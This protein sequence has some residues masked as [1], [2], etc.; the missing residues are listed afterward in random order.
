MKTFKIKKGLD[1]PLKGVPE[2]RIAGFTETSFYGL[3]G[4]DYVG[5]KPKILVNEGDFVRKGEALF[6]HKK[7]ERIKFT[8]PVAGRVESINRGEK[9]KFLSV[10]IKK[11]SDDSLVFDKFSDLSSLSKEKITEQ[12]LNSG[13][14][15]SI[16][17]RPYGKIA[18]P[19]VVPNDIF[20]TATDTRPLAPDVSVVLERNIESFVDGIKILSK[21][22]GHRL[23][24]CLSGKNLKL[25]EHIAD[26]V[27]KV[28]FEGPHPSGLAGTH[29]HFLSPVSRN[30]TVWQVNYQDVIAIGK[31]FRT[32]EL[33]TK[34][35][36]SVA[37]DQINNPCLLEVDMGVDTKELTE[38]RLVDGK[39]RI[40]SGSPLYGKKS[41]EPVNFLGRY[42]MQISAIA[43]GGEREFF[44]WIS[45]GMKKFSVK[46][47]FFSSLNRKARF[48]FDTS[49]GGSRRA[50]VPVGTYEKVV[51][52][53]IIPTYLLRSLETG[54]YE[55]AEK[56]GCLELL[57][58]DLS[59][60]TFVCPGK[61]DHSAN[62]RK[63]LTTM[64]KET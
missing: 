28:V 29:I 59:L 38:E 40:I 58:E 42:D 52:M 13:M 51:P 36:I 61:I 57:E 50:I 18:N 35:I 45:P 46:N 54:D 26:N 21:L 7:D 11:T 48:S 4:E 49:Y 1:I 53:D 43:E 41:E 6:I 17:S 62:L 55:T 63:I 60:C 14:W 5:L 33:Y 19:D 12:L 9:R 64:E 22:S 44:G 8:S 31:L 15:T 39:T 47:I 32:G 30:K 24:V 20:V 23:F 25:P 2:Q 34:R 27:E 10:I 56:L 3:L 37:G 16:I